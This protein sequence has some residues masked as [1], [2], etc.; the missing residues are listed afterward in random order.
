[1]PRFVIQSNVV[2]SAICVFGMFAGG[3]VMAQTTS[4]TGAAST[5]IGQPTTTGGSLDADAAFSQVERGSTVG[6]TGATGSGFSAA[7]SSNG[8]TTSR[9]VSS[10]GGFGGGLG[11]LGGLQGLFG[12][13]GGQAQNSKPAIRTRLR[14][15]IEGDRPPLSIDPQNA[16]TRFESLDR[17][18]FQSVMVQVKDGVG[19]LTGVVPSPRERRMSELLLRLEPGVREVKNDLQVKP[20]S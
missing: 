1:M 2:F 17:P 19:T 15:A 7:S 20:K 13:L 10:F 8:G 9:G 3:N 11:A 16:G 6:A 18:Q 4:G 14:S 5:T 12:G